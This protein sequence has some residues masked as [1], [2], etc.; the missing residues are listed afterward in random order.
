MKR[1]GFTLIELLVVIAII[2]ILAAILFPVFAQ[3]KEAAKKTSAISALKQYGLGGNMYSTDYDDMFQM[4]FGLRP[5]P[6]NTWGWNVITPYPPGWFDDGIWAIPARIDMAK[7]HAMNSVQPY[8][9]NYQLGELPGKGSVQWNSPDFTATRLGAPAKVGVNY[10]GLLMGISSS[11]VNQPSRV[12]M[13]STLQGNLN[14]EGR[15]LTNPG[16]LC[17]LGPT[18]ATPAPCYYN[19]GQ[20]MGSNFFQGSVW[21]YPNGAAP[22]D[23]YTGGIVVVRTDSSAKLYKLNNHTATNKNI[24]EPWSQYGAVAGN[25]VGMRLCELALNAPYFSCFFSPDQDGTRTLWYQILE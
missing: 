24:L 18:G 13:Y 11:S 5:A 10:N 8:M 4:G 2:A 15:C 16:M 19:S 7:D 17:D 1:K 20:G 6:A 14:S 25:P 22:G 9:K 12:P 3:A 23:L 21:F